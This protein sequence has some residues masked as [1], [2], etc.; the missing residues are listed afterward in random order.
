MFKRESRQQ[1]RP[2]EAT[3]I[4][5]H[6]RCDVDVTARGLRL[7]LRVPRGI[8]T[9]ARVRMVVEQGGTAPGRIDVLGHLAFA[10]PK[11]NYQ[12]LG[13]ELVALF[14]PGG[15]EC[16]SYFITQVLQLA[17][18]DSSAFTQGNGGHYI[19]LRATTASDSEDASD[20]RNETR[21]PVKPQLDAAIIIGQVK[22]EGKLVD[23]SE[24]GIGVKTRDVRP[25]EGSRL[26]LLCT[27][28]LQGRPYE[29][30]LFGTIQWQ[31]FK[32]GR[33]SHFGVKL[34]LVNDGRGG[35]L[36]KRYVRRMMA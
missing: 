28:S 35:T 9:P 13:I 36:W 30:R 7:S 31:R 33:W 14:T 17:S 2:F 27:V 18:P 19:D 1:G 24:S 25:Q 12:A 21:Y 32:D 3:L 10:H 20:R 29:V 6:G 16:L 26:E 11:G 15:E 34:S 4:H 23:V 5:E 22:Y 8:T